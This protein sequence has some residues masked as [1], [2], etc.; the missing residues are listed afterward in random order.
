MSDW[1]DEIHENISADGLE[2]KEHPIE[3]TAV[4]VLEGEAVSEG[5]EVYEEE[6]AGDLDDQGAKAGAV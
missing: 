6:Q 2:V 5:L 3:D 1:W 4:K